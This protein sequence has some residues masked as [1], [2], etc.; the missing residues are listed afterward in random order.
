MSS[1]LLATLCFVQE[2]VVP[3]AAAGAAASGNTAVITADDVRPHVAFLADPARGGRPGG[4][5]D[6]AADYI[7]RHFRGLGLEPMFP[8]NGGDPFSQPVPGGEVYPDGRNV[9][10]V[11]RG[12][13]PAVADEVILVGAHYDHLGVRGGRLYPGADDNASG[14]AMLLEVAERL[15][16]AKRDG[17]GPRRT[18]AFAGFDLEERMLFGSRWFAAHPPALLTAGDP[19]EMDRLKLVLVADMIGRS[20]GDLGLP[21]V[22]V[23]GGENAPVTRDLLDTAEADPAVT[24][25]AGPNSLEVA[26]M[27]IDLIGT[28]S[29]YGPF[30]DREIPFLFFST[31]EHRD[32]HR[33]TDTPERLDHDRAAAV[34]TLMLAVTRAA[35]DAEAAP[36]WN[37]DPTPHL[38]EAAAL[39]RIAN[40]LLDE[41]DARNFG[42]VQRLTLS[43]AKSTTDAI[44]ARGT[45]TPAE[46]TWLLRLGQVM[47]L[48]VF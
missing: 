34:S 36:V 37:P 11:L 48:S 26:R 30:R 17:N 40:R 5:A 4:D 14:T 35:A 29:D 24:E 20:L 23:L 9:G 32:Y 16:H 25:A 46:R 10:A 2:P 1:L 41:A 21:T 33:P 12:S 19:G 47:M 44:L 43:Q 7:V 28:R 22:F 31:G 27:G 15:A 42:G 8:G 18:V 13:D 38:A 39:N 6:E 45:M 3:P